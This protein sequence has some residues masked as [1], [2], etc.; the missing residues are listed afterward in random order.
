MADEQPKLCFLRGEDEVPDEEAG[1]DGAKGMGQLKKELQR[2]NFKVETTDVLGKSP[3]PADCDVLVIAG[4]T[5]GFTPPEADAL[6]KWV[7]GGGRLL[8]LVDPPFSR[9]GSLQ[10]LGIEQV[11][12]D[13]G[14]VIGDDIVLDPSQKLLFGTAESFAASDFPA[15]E[16]TKDLKDAAVIF[17]LA[18]S[19]APAPTPP[20]GWTISPLARTTAEGWGE[21]DLAHLGA[22]AKGPED[23]KGPVPVAVAAE[24]TLE[25]GKSARVVAVGDS[26]FGHNNFLGAYANLDFLLN[27]V[28]WLVGRS[29]Q[30][31][32]TP[33]EP[34]HVQ[35]AMTGPQEKG[36]IVV[37]LFLLP[38]LAVVSGI[39]VWFFRRR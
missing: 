17:G 28:H 35:L 7:D 8:A 29:E 20:A 16:I 13:R 10:K 21:R 14:I 15:H 9:D 4:P 22:V 30:I 24:K 25:G 37:T 19:V 2:E 11:L 33:R 38:G 5:R 1:A 6:A 26:D 3:L 18:R 12:R 27:S 39:V 23:L 36:V 34:E 31:G 32:I